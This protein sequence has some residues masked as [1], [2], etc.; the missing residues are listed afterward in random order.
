MSLVSPEAVIGSGPVDVESRL[1]RAP[2]YGK[3]NLHRILEGRMITPAYVRTMAA[4]NAEMNKRLYEAAGRLGDAERRA[5][6]GAFWGSIHGT[7]VHILWGDSQWMSRFDGWPPPAVGQRQSD[8]FIEN[9]EELRAARDKGDADISR[10]ADK[11][12]DAWL[13]ADLVWFSGSAGRE[14][15]APKRLL[16][17]HFFNHQTHHRGQAHALLT[18]AGQQ[19]GDTDLFLVIPEMIE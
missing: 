13:D 4:Y 10:W 15:R 6:Q 19:T 17:T 9:W 7:L 2:T 5:S 12:D 3:R 18:A 8:H 14:I 11:V 1:R 16:V